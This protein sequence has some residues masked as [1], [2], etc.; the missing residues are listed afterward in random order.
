MESR[1]VRS[2]RKNKNNPRAGALFEQKVQKYFLSKNKIHLENQVPFLLGIRKIKRLHKF[3]LASKKER[4]IVECKS[5]TWT[6]GG[7]SPSAK[8]G[9]LNEVMF[10]FSLA[11]K[12][13]RKVLVMRK[14]KRNGVSL[15]NH[16]LKN[17]EHLIP[18]RVEI[19]EM[20]G[21]KAQQVY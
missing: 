13:Y 10:Y 14:H 12:D 3:D 18:G 8:F 6:V 15:A 1:L 20:A 5:Y 9:F 17:H 21:M 7:N 11:P 4:I 2:S 19:W 16:Y